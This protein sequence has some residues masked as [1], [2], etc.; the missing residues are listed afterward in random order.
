VA[1]S[2]DGT[3]GPG[4]QPYLRKPAP[5]MQQQG[6]LGPGPANNGP[7]PGLSFMNFDL[8]SGSGSNAPLSHG[9]SYGGSGSGYDSFEV[10]APLLE[11]T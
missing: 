7:G 10:E 2:F 9:R 6:Q 4:G 1:L 5:H 11:G 8:P 3:G